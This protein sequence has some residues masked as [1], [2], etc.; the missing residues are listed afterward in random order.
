MTSFFDK[1]QDTILGKLKGAGFVLSASALQNDT[2]IIKIANII[3][4]LLPTPI[5]FIVGV[6]I[7]E[8]FLLKNREW[9]INKLI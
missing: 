6:D 2:N 3:Y 5:R 9:L 4:N 7:V 8:N 1:N